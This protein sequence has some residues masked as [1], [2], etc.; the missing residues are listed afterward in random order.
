MK[1]AFVAQPFDGVLPPYQNSIGLIIFNTARCLAKQAEVTVYHP[2]RGATESVKEQYGITFRQMPTGPDRRFLDLLGGGPKLVDK[3]K[4]FASWV[5]YLYYIS[6]IAW[7]ARN[8]GYDIMHIVNF[9]QFAPVVKKFNPATQVVLEMQCEWLAQLDH[10]TIQKRLSRVDMVAGVSDHITNGVLNSFPDLAIPCRTAYNG[11]DPERFG[12]DDGCE[13][14]SPGQGKPLLF[15]GRVSPEKGVHVLVEAMA[16]VVRQVPDAKLMIVGSR[17]SLPLEYIVGL[18]D[19]EDL[20]NL[21]VFYDGTLAVDYQDYLDK[22]VR[23][24]NLD[25]N[26]EFTGGM[27]QAEL[28]SL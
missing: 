17:S 21:S 20:R 1:I 7:D 26:I 3:S 10:A 22:R 24:L 12:G 13:E 25:N 18:S 23:E 6:R 19:D 2:Q 9:S 11:V 15:I 8:N 16:E 5:Y 28:I 27:P 14:K 4:A